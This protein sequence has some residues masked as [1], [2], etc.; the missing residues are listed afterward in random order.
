MHV[1]K[2]I[3][4]SLKFSWVKHL[5]NYGLY[6]HVLRLYLWVANTFNP[7]NSLIY[8]LQTSHKQYESMY[9]QFIF[10]KCSEKNKHF[11]QNL[12]PTTWQFCFL[13]ILGLNHLEIQLRIQI[14]KIS[15]NFRSYSTLILKIVSELNVH[16]GI[17]NHHLKS[18][19]CIDLLCTWNN[20]RKWFP[21]IRLQFSLILRSFLFLHFRY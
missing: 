6:T 17:I 11:S 10:S 1:R 16:I 15:N 9:N 20:Q 7:T 3:L 12:W 4:I 2:H 8:L 19:Y 14:N 5:L 21:L 18:K 13:K